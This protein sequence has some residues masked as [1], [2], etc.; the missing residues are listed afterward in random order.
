ML[1]L[2]SSFAYQSWRQYTKDYPACLGSCHVL[3]LLEWIAIIFALLSWR[4][5]ANEAA[6]SVW[7]LNWLHSGWAFIWR[8]RIKVCNAWFWR[9]AI[10]HSWTT[11]QAF[12]RTSPFQWKASSWQVYQIQWWFNKKRIFNDVTLWL[13]QFSACGAS[14]Q[15]TPKSQWITHAQI[16]VKSMLHCLAP[17]VG[18]HCN[19][20]SSWCENKTPKL[21]VPC[22]I[23]RR[24]WRSISSCFTFRVSR[25]LQTGFG[26]FCS[27]TSPVWQKHCCV[28]LQGFIAYNQWFWFQSIYA[29]SANHCIWPSSIH[30]YLVCFFQTT[31]RIWYL[32]VESPLRFYSPASISLPLWKIQQLQAKI[33]QVRMN[34]AVYCSLIKT[35]W[36]LPGKIKE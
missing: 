23:I 5:D 9:N 12:G 27:N 26:I 8:A 34:H 7:D 24:I 35:C 36:N 4:R 33:S 31:P 18:L 16:I 22:S 32:A 3:H 10:L 19:P 15:N 11:L 6:F 30:M 29:I 14:S 1:L 21:D 13:L 17:A 28:L 2:A 20:I 25:G